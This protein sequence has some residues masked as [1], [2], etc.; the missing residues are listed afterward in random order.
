MADDLQRP[1]M[2]SLQRRERLMDELR[3]NGSVHIRDIAPVLGVSE[4]TVRRDINAMAEQGL[5]TR[6]HGGATLSGPLDAAP[7]PART[8]FPSR[9]TLG[10]VVPSLDYYW[11]HVVSGARAAATLAQARLVLRGSSYDADDDRRQIERLL[12]STEVHGLVAAPETGDERGRAL[13]RWLDTLPIPVVLAERRAPRDLPAQNLEWV[14]TDHPFGAG[15]AVRHL[16][17][18]GHRRIGLL[19]ARHSPTSAHVLTGWQRTVRELGL[20]ADDPHVIE[21]D[22]VGAHR[23]EVLTRVLEHCRRSGTTALLVHADPEALA[24][25]QTCLDQG[26]RVPEDLAVVAYD[27]EVAHLSQ[28]AL[29]AVRPP[30]EH[31]GRTA[32]E[33]LLARLQEG[34]RRPVHRVRVN[35]ALVVRESSSPPGRE[36]DPPPP[37]R[38]NPRTNPRTTPGT[39]PDR[40][41]T[42]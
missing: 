28:P 23:E 5:L 9:Y 12:G 41:R 7:A 8:R 27:D 22:A 25:A 36:P 11:P 15:L 6:V 30:K 17:A 20:P 32:V 19:L 35:P 1:S 14:S 10:M 31:V 38:T 42:R 40:R 3:R 24:L 37:P 29:S 21:L 16:H 26:V 33:L 34:D 2:F 39:A 13:L 4:L 18:G